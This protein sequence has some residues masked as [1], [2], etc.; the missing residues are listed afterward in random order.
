MKRNFSEWLSKFRTSV[1]SW[2]YYV[3]FPKVYENIRKVKVELNILNSLIGSQNIA[4]DFRE[5]V[6]KY[7]E[8]IKV[9]PN[10]LAKRE[11]E[12][13]IT[14]AKSTRTFSFKD[15]VHTTEEY[16]MFMENTGLFS[17]MKN[18]I[19]QNLVDYV[20]G[21][22][23]GMDTNARKNRTGTAMEN[24]VETY[25]LDLGLVKD[26]TY[27]KEMSITKIEK[28]TNLKLGRISNKGKTEKRFDFVVIVKG[29]VYAIECNF[30]GANGSKLNET[31]RSYKNLAV[32]A[33]DINGFSFVWVTDGIGWNGA[34][35]NLEETFNILET[36]YSLDD[37]EAG[38]FKKLFQ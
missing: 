3:D 20:T 38:A 22:E 12:I 30:Y 16:I 6:A 8:V 32:E 27:F 7:P 18:H 29:H 36:M 17:L 9:I 19:I 28:M 11:K 2:D 15:A 21:V 25:L 34:R 24:I 10:L 23:V 33:K 26:Q 4:D 13:L 5:L 31:A 35:N 1:A 37:L 14:D